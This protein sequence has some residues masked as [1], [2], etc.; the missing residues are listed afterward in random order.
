[1]APQTSRD[2]QSEATQGVSRW[3]QSIEH[4][5]K[6]EILREILD[7]TLRRKKRSATFA[8]ALADLHPQ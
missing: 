1:M 6:P 3:R 4:I 7:K 5:F 8:F 2:D